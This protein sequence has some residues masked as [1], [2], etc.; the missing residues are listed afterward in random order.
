MDSHEVLKNAIE[1][2]GAKAVASELYISPSLLY[3]WC[4][5]KS[6]PNDCGARN[7]LDRMIQIYE[8]TRDV[9]PI[10]WL[11]EKTD[12]FRVSN[13]RQNHPKKTTMTRRAILEA[14]ICGLSVP[15]KKK[16]MKNSA[17]F[18]LWR[19]SSL[20][21]AEKTVSK[22]MLRRSFK[23]LYRRSLARLAALIMA[24]CEFQSPK[25]V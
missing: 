20:S 5:P 9:G 11:C 6:M 22:S 23:H 24:S 8:I 14:L 15:I 17:S 3:K 10:E 12:G 18:S 21:G 2:A 16:R 4:E 13:P 7:P 25:L 19:K 1:T